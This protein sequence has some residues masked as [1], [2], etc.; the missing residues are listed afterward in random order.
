MHLF[1][2][3]Q[4]VPQVPQFELSLERSLQAVAHADIPFEQSGTQRPFIH[5]NVLGQ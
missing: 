4:V 1:P 2:E 5:K 3:S